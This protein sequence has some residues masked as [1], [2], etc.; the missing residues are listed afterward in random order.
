MVATPW[1][2]SDSLRDRRLRPGPGVPREDVVGNQRER[3]FGAMV[4]SVSERGYAGTT[5]NDLVKISGVS[6]RTFYD[7]FGDKQS[8]FVAAVE[9]IIEAAMVYAARTAE[10]A[11]PSGS[12]EEHARR[13][14][15]AFA[16]M[17]ARQPAAARMALIEAYAAGPE[18]LAPVEAAIA[19][20]EW[21]TRK[22]LEQSPERAEMPAELVTAHIGAQQEIARTR[23]RRGAEGELPVLTNQ[24]WELISSFRPPPEPL[25]LVG[26]MPKPE[27]ETVAAHS[28]AE[29]ALRAFSV[30]VAENGYMDATIDEVLKRGQMSA[31]T[32]YAHFEG[33]EDAM[34][35][36]VDTACAQM[37]AAMTP[38]FAR[39]DDWTDGIRAAYGGML[40]FLASR[41]ALAKLI[42]V[43][44]Y[45]AGGAAIERRDLGL[46]PFDALIA[47][48]TS[49]W[50]L[51]PPVVYESIRGAF[52]SLLYKTVHEA[53]A[54]ALPQLAPVC[55]YFTLFPFVGPEVACA[56][57]NGSGTARRQAPSRSSVADG[58]TGSLPFQTPVTPTIMHALSWLSEISVD[59]VETTASAGEVAAEVGEDVEVVRG[60]LRDLAAAGVLEIVGDAS[61][62]G[63]GEAR[64][65]SRNRLHPM[66]IASAQQI[67]MIAPQEREAVTSRVWDM[68]TDDL[69]R[70]RRSGSF[71]GRPD[72]FITRTPMRVDEEGWRELTSLHEQLVHSGIEIQARSA[73]RLE[74]SGEEGFEARSV[75]LVFEMPADA[76]GASPEDQ[77]E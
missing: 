9:A 40:N 52:H 19:G 65:R 23:L 59:S 2:D 38:A 7:L 33:K 63:E 5:V 58:S 16:E 72:R 32:F 71:E 6:S 18:G 62:E 42:S 54:E 10:E 46:Q 48:N 61:S 13:G 77:S 76:D 67:A 47:N 50:P 41:P 57:A 69:D 39:Q 34:L 4:A 14:F 21:L 43:E 8:C 60:Y 53:G 56:A 29:R 25:R 3:L 70:A 75:Q 26:R 11:D 27:P 37:I 35:A 15:D 31:T 66:Q 45:S 68:I 74:G 49:A 28:H 22:T 73:K 51:M 64:Y 1:G 55:T 44:V 30:V 36:A 17:V 20:F 12:W 24:L